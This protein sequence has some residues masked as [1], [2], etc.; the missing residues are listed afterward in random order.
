MIVARMVD[1]KF[2][3]S[4]VH[5]SFFLEGIYLK[6]RDTTYVQSHTRLHD[7][8]PL[9]L[10]CMYARG[11]DDDCRYTV[12][13]TVNF[14]GGRVT[15]IAVHS[16]SS[17]DVNMSTCLSHQPISFMYQILTLRIVFD[18]RWYSLR[19]KKNVYITYTAKMGRL[20]LW[21]VC[22]EMPLSNTCWIHSHNYKIYRIIIV[23]HKNF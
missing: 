10:L 21:I 5:L 16:R 15:D 7:R 17:A 18:I 12:H 22:K 13:Y 6:R 19:K 2:G 8:G 11:T 20:I 4:P 3:L 9:Y 14:M 1:I 23:A